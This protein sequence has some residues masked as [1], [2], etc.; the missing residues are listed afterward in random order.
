V[1]IKAGKF[2]K[3]GRKSKSKLPGEGKENDMD[4]GQIFQDF[5]RILMNEIRDDT[6]VNNVD[7]NHKEIN[8]MFQARSLWHKIDTAEKKSELE[9]MIAKR[10]LV[11]EEATETVMAEGVTGEKASGTEPTEEGL[12]ELDH[13][14]DEDDYDDTLDN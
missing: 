13:E 12:D 8:Q 6:I 9:Y 14:N 2:V 11:Y 7:F 4:A 1:R 5:V 10:N 3:S